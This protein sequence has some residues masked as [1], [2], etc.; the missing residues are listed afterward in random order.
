MGSPNGAICVPLSLGVKLIRLEFFRTVP[1][2]PPGQTAVLG[3]SIHEVI[4]AVE[5]HPN[6]PG[7]D[8][9][10]EIT[11][12]NTRSERQSLNKFP[13]GGAFTPAPT[14]T[15]L[16]EQRGGACGVSQACYKAMLATLAYSGRFRSY[17]APTAFLIAFIFARNPAAPSYPSL[18]DRCDESRAA[19]VVAASLFDCR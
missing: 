10:N 19:S 13:P 18:R 6:N 12:L 2:E 17:W 15:Q 5:V 16:G 14:G 1:D 11:L 7:P 9:S 3:L 4:G 8:F